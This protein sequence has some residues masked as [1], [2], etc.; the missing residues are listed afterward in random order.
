MTTNARHVPRPPPC[1]KA[2]PVLQCAAQGR[3]THQLRLSMRPRILTTDPQHPTTTAPLHP[4]TTDPQHTMTTDPQHPTTTDL[5]HTMTTAPQ[6]TMIT[7]LHHHLA[8]LHHPEAT[9]APAVSTADRHSP[10][11]PP[12]TIHTPTKQVPLSDSPAH[13]N[14]RG[15]HH[16]NNTST[17][18]T[19]SPDDKTDH[20]QEHVARRSNQRLT[21]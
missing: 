11:T 8:P 4:T 3:H 12:P 15:H 2:I 17:T 16:N 18:S 6:H 20:L 10:R 14:R 7:D 5:Q 21:R 13:T 1:T 9:G 19:T